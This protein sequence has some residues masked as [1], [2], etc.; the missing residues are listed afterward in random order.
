MHIL[1]AT[2]SFK[3]SLSALE[4]GECIK[5][6]MSRQLPAATFDIAPM[7]DG[8]EGTIEAALLSV[9][10][11]RVQLEV[12]G[13]LMEKVNAQY[14]VFQGQTVFIEC[15]QSSGLPLVPMAQRT[16]MKTN[17]YGFGEMIKAA[18]MKGYRTINL[19]LGGSATNDAGIGMLQALGWE[20][21]DK[22]GHKIS[23]FDG[24]PLLTVAVMNADNVIP[25]LKECTFMVACDVTNPFYGEQGA[26]YIFAGQKGASDKDIVQLDDAM[27]CFAKLIQGHYGVDMQQLQGAGAA[28][29]LGGTI[30]AALNGRMTSGVQWMIDFIGLEARIKHA[31][32]V[33]T[34]EGSL[35]AQSLMGKVPF[36]VATLAY[37]FGKPVIGLAGRIDTNLDLHNQMF[38]GIFSIQSECR[39][40]EEALRPEVTRAQ[41]RVTAEQIARLITAI[42]KQAH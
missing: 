34:G 6:G 14:A 35:D 21:F 26:A 38:N 20:F 11:E 40:L 41:L 30:M 42:Y 18:I 33:I 7:A 27:R 15:A 4:I 9:P 31:D 28:G 10:G 2:D 8:G 23:P 29:G 36:G 25:Q 3:D 22:A 13:P 37:Q 39:S 5:D 17:S 1:I 24:N 12:H 16:P 32:L 19:S